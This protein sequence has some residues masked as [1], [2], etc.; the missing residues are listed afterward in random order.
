MTNFR[1]KLMNHVQEV[2]KIKDDREH[3]EKE[4]MSYYK[5]Y[6]EHLGKVQELTRQLNKKI[7]DFEEYRIKK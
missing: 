2:L 3:H 4:K 1:N 6:R 5:K 7:E